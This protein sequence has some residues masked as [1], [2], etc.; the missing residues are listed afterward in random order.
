MTTQVRERSPIDPLSSQHV[1][2]VER[3]E[4]LRRKGF[5]RAEHHVA[6]IVNDDVDPARLGN[7]AADRRFD[8]R[9]RLDIELDGTQVDVVLRGIGVSRLDLRRIAPF[10]FT[11]SGIDRMPGVGE[12]ARGKGSKA[13]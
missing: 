11:H 12:L 9:L 2:I 3:C 5:G 8:R 4:L 7:D 10:R 6:G 13:G 1:D